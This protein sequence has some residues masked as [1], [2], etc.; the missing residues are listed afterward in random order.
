[1]RLS[2]TIPATKHHL[3]MFLDKTKDLPGVQ[4]DSC[5]RQKRASAA[6]S[7][8]LEAQYFEKFSM[9]VRKAADRR[10]AGLPSLLLVAALCPHKT[11]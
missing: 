3:K 6:D 9:A 5:D 11:S 10:R 8:F 1:M 7:A 2:D 4:K